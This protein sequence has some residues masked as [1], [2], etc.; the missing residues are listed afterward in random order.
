M[1]IIAELSAVILPVFLCAGVGFIWAKLKYP[2]DNQ[3]ITSLVYNIGA[4][5]LII[6]TFAKVE[7][8]PTAL[9]ELAGAALAAYAAFTVIGLVVLK[10]VRLAPQSYLPSLMFPLTG[11][12]GLPICLFAFGSDGLALALVFFM[13][14]TVGTFT[15][16]AAIAAGKISL[17]TIL[18]T[19]T[20]YAVILA[21]TL[22][23]TDTPLPQWA[24]NITNLLG[25]IVIPTQL[26]AL[27]VALA[28][29]RITSLSRSVSLAVLRLGMGVIIGLAVAAI[30]DLTG[31]ARAVVIVQCTMPVAVSNY[32]FAQ[33]YDREP[34]EV[35]GMVLVSTMISFATLP[36]L[37]MLVW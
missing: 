9:T 16:G 37:L 22:E 35:A 18:R 20:I 8:S 30:F 33:L 6:A 32:L 36:L 21:V 26:I 10:S 4:P 24:F 28:A 14:G 31:V 2:F 5:C 25:N 1:G 27:G 15:I 3:I 17:A 7:L 12:M 23:V 29:L 34:E 13:I 19:P 11:S